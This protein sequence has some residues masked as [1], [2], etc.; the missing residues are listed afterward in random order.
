VAATNQDLERMVRTGDFRSDLYHRLGQICL[1]VPPLRERNDDIIPLAE[2]FLRQ[3]NPRSFFSGDA[4]Q[5]MRRYTWPGNV[6]ELRN[7]VTK[8]AVLARDLEIRSDDMMLGQVNVEREPVESITGQ[9]ASPNLDGMEKNTILRVLAQTNGHQ[10]RAAELLGI[11]RRTLSRK[12]KLYGRDS[13]RQ[14]YAS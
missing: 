11:S 4:L 1:R 6:R 8:A 14:S 13:V 7:V 12:L 10:Q 3:S 9:S 2:H 5:T